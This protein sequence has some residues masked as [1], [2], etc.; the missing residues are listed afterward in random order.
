[1]HDEFIEHS[2]ISTTA[3]SLIT[4]LSVRVSQVPLL[5][6]WKGKFCVKLNIT[7]PAAVNW[8]LNKV[9]SLHAQLGME[10]VILEGGEGNP[11][12]E[13]A[14]QPPKA[15]A[16]DEYIGLLAGVAAK[17]GDT[18][19]VTSGTRYVQ[20]SPVFRTNVHDLLFIHFLPLVSSL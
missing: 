20:M 19:I 4:P 5:M 6:Q 15:L 17:I 8:F 7:N 18:A 2:G 10:Y 13:Q 11:F 1:M 16:G 3:K 12:K 9:G 14:M